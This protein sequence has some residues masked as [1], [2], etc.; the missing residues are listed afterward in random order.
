VAL[1]PWIAT[2]TRDELHRLLRQR[3]EALATPPPV[4]DRALARCARLGVRQSRSGRMPAPSPLPPPTAVTAM[5]TAVDSTPPEPA[6]SAGVTVA[7]LAPAPAAPPTPGALESGRIIAGYRIEGLL[8]KGGMGAVYRA[9]QLS[10]SRPVAFKVLAAR[11]ARDPTFVGRFKREARAAGRLHHPNLITVH[12]WGEADG[13]VFFSMELVEGRSLKDVLKEQG[14]LSP[15][16]ALRVIRPVLEA[17]AYA[18]GKG[19]I[20]RDIKP[21]NVMVADGGAVKIA[22]LGLSRIDEAEGTGSSDT[23]LFQTTAGSFMGTPHYMAPEQGRDAHAVDHR[24]DIYSVGATLY[25]L[26]CGRPPFGGSTPMEV[27][28]AAQS[29]PLTW[30]EHAPPPALRE[31]IARLMARDPVKRP[32]TA[33]AALAELDKA[34]HAQQTRHAPA[35]RLARLRRLLLAAVGLCLA[36]VMVLYALDF[37]TKQGQ[38]RAWNETLATAEREADRKAFAEALQ[39]LRLAREQ[40]PSQEIATLASCD[41]AMAEISKAWDAWSL[42]QIERVER[43]VREAIRSDR[44]PEALEQ[45]RKVPEAWR[46]PEGAGRLEG[47][48]SELMAAVARRAKGGSTGPLDEALRQRRERGNEAWA[49]ARVEPAGNL[50][51]ENGLAVFQASGSGTMPLPPPHGPL[52]MAGLRL[53]WRILPGSGGSWSLGFGNDTRLVM[54]A[55]AAVIEGPHGSKMLAAVRNGQVILGLGRRGRDLY[56]MAPGHDG[57]PTTLTL[58]DPGNEASLAWDLKG[59]ELEIGLGKR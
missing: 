46:S 21:D 26:V 54:R 8:G 5:V 43:S 45:L 34:A 52:G 20:H 38:V 32:E 23:E 48:E 15:D 7:S 53:A 16:E 17:L 40:I 2:M 49:K 4:I 28:I 9:T 44:F 59:G 6:G 11:L 31:S 29:Q 13:L 19:V 39:R 14:R 30:P 51:V 42:P 58:P 27:M 41:A 33:T 22:D 12:D 56:I 55:D 10:M 1:A 24:C 37:V 25:H 47:L 50:T 3:A 35:R 18:H 57:R 36:S